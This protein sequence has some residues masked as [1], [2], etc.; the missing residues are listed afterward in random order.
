MTAG[1]EPVASHTCSCGAP[2]YFPPVVPA[3]NTTIPKW[4]VGYC[5]RFPSIC[6]SK[7]FIVG[8]VWV[9]GTA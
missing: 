4:V 2:L 6:P 1:A 3:T 9:D 5:S 7:T 8:G